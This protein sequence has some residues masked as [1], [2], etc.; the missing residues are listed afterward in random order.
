L[1]TFSWRFR[2]LE[3]RLEILVGLPYISDKDSAGGG[4]SCTI[5]VL[6][7]KVYL[8]ESFALANLVRPPR[9]NVAVYV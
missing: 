2:L 5:F 8:C 9:C 4:L 3:F 6:R 1:S 7:I